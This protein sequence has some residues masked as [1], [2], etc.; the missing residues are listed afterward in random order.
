MP[1][2][3]DPVRVERLPIV[4]PPPSGEEPDDIGAGHPL[5]EITE[6][7]AA[8]QQAWTPDLA[9]LVASFFDEVAP[10]WSRRDG[11]TEVLEALQD[12]MQRGGA[13]AMPVVELG[14]GTGAGTRLLA[15]RFDHVVA[16]DLSSGMLERLPAE[17]AARVRLD[18]SA[19]PF[20]DG[21][22][23]TLVCVNMLLFP[24]EVDRVLRTDGALVWVNSIGERTPIHL[25]VDTLATVL[26]DG[27][28][29]T[30]SRAGWGTWVVARVRGRGAPATPRWSARRGRR[31]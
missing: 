14:A 2:S 5:R 18:S 10:S 22:I 6:R 21:S 3:F 8:D 23:G 7:V 19:L 4:V 1:V 12:A 26:G 27:Y 24:D 28:E 13:M 31:S 20:P 11:H 25:S 30:A 16:G 29:L 9:A 15:D 17:L